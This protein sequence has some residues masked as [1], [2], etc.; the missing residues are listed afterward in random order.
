MR[1]RKPFV[2]SLLSVALLGLLFG[3]A[4]CGERIIPQGSGNLLVVNFQEGKTLR[5]RM[6]SVR[7][8]TIELSSAKAGTKQG[9]PQKMTESLEMVMAYT[10]VKVDPFGL[11]KLECVCESAAVTRGSFTGK[12]GVSVDAV[13]NLKGKPFVLELSPTGKI[14]DFTQLETLLLEIGK[15]AFDTTRKDA[16]V[17]NPDMIYDFVAMQW[18]L[19]DS[20]ASVTDPLSGVKPGMKWTDTQ[21]VAWPVPIPNTPCRVTTFMLD[22]V[23]EN[24]DARKAIIKSTY[25]I[26]DKTL[27]T[28]PKPYEGTFQMRGLFGFLRD[29]QFKSL[30]GGGEV[31]F[32]LSSGTVESDKQQYKLI[33]SAAFLLPLGDSQPSVVVEQSIDIQ[34]LEGKP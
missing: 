27:G 12:G 19:W 33:A 6:K 16:S 8:T 5:Y 24:E 14:Q 10:P 11:T 7:D 31:A 28:F 25:Q 21:V 1:L 13:E 2:N 9:K 17:K 22:S 15:T 23:Q 34:L 3:L 26:S 32:N 4:G 20:I 18:Y 30:E 29:Y